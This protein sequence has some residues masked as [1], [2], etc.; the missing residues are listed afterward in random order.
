MRKISCSVHHAFSLLRTLDPHRFFI[1]F[2]CWVL[3]RHRRVSCLVLNRFRNGCKCSQIRQNPILVYQ[4]SKVGSTSMFYSLQVAYAKAGLAHVPIHHVHTLRYLEQRER[5]AGASGC[6][7]EK[8]ALVRKYQRIWRDFRSRP[9]GHW[10]VIS[11]V[12]D[13]VARHISNYFHHIDEHLPGW[14]RRWREGGL[15]ID[16]MVGNFLGV[17]DH[18]AEHWFDEEI[19]AVLGI[20]VFASLFPHNIGYALYQRPPKVT[21]MVIRMEDMNRGAPQAVEQLLGIR[22]FK[23][24]SFNAADQQSYRDL[25]RLFKSQPLPSW[26]VEKAYSGRLARHFY[27]DIERENFARKWTGA[28]GRPRLDFVN[29]R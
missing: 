11:M 12:R 21:L 16:D 15:S 5:R 22:D 17:I 8:L 10:T 26:Y 3:Q 29:A 9:D 13:P 2:L 1:V 25:Y 18:S 23:L 7:A 27:S 4:M 6:M 28:V 24:Y 14:R 20:D 19:D